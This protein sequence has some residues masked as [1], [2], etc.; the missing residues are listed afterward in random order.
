M[1]TEL[2]RR[3]LLLTVLLVWGARPIFPSI[4][5]WALNMEVEDSA[6]ITLSRSTKD[7]LPENQLNNLHEWL[8][9]TE[10]TLRTLPIKNGE[11]F[12]R[13]L[14]KI[15]GNFAKLIQMSLQKTKRQGSDLDRFDQGLETLFQDKIRLE[16]NIL[17][18]LET[19]GLK[20]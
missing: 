19:Y 6:R 2:I 8:V 7:Q 17:R 9:L 12:L 4:M 5:R 11:D 15:K 18:N 10:T 14:E 1:P 16:N 20:V 3:G 13:H